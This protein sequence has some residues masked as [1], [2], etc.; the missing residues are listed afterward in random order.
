MQTRN[1]A[2]RTIYKTYPKTLSDLVANRAAFGLDFKNIEPK[3]YDSMDAQGVPLERKR[4]VYRDMS[5]AA[6]V[7]KSVSKDVSDVIEAAKAEKA[8]ADAAA[9]AGDE[10][11]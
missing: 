3:N 2:H 10:S 4:F 6:S 9:S 5:V 1:P 8:A 11:S 7:F